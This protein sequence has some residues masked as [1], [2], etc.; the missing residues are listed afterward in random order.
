MHLA[1]V[2]GSVEML[3]TMFDLQPER[4]ASSIASRDVVEHTPLHK[5]VLFDRREAVEFLLDKVGLLSPEQV[6]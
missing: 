2:N 4:L 3:R 1:C 5:A 6:C